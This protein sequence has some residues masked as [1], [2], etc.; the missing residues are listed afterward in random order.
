MLR[1]FLHYY[2][3]YRRLF[4]LDITTAILGA[5][6]ALF[7]PVV[8][9]RLLKQD[10]V[11]KD[12]NGIWIGLG[13]VA[14]LAVLQAVCRFVNTYWGHILGTRMEADMRSDLFRHL[15]KLSYTFYD[16]TKTGHLI[17]RIANDLFNVAELA[18]HG[19]EDLLIS[20]V[21][22]LGSFGFMLWFSPMLALVALIPLPFMVAWAMIFGSKMRRGWRL[23]RQRIADINSGVENAIQ[24]IREVKSFTNEEYEIDRFD[25]ANLEFRRAKE[26]MYGAMAGFHAGMM[27]IMQTYS[28]VIVGGGLVL[29]HSGRIELAD[30]IVFMLYSRFVQQPLHRLTGFVEQFQ[31]GVAAFERFTEIMDVEPDVVDRP[32]A[33]CL[34]SVRGDVTL[35][36]VS[37]RYSENGDWVLNDVTLEIPAGRSVALVGESGAGK[38]TLAALIPRFYEAQRGRVTIDGHDVLDLERRFLRENVGVVQQNVFLFDSTLR[39]NIMFGSPEATE[40]QL[41]EAARRANIL[42]FI[43]SLPEGF[44]STVGEHGVKLSGGQKQRISIARVFLKNPPIL[45]FDE[46]TSSLDSESEQLI[47][48]AM[49]ELCR[50]RT[51]L[52]IAHRFTTVRSADHTYVLSDG[53]IVE[54][55][56]HDEL[57]ERPGYYSKLY[58]Q[59]TI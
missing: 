42:D 34:D 51:T 14:T 56:R 55:G 6:F 16:N 12:L 1:R 47:K 31:Q 18:H 9:G 57:I 46:A 29:A 52:I 33:L 22:I 48:K 10:L 40:E 58:A 2:R 21:M 54:Q 7:I 50:D 37:F 30:I 39:E 25:N 5:A 11:A 3:P 26:Q 28:L 43:E 49:H 19:P 41:I 20:V 8:V 38:S 17:S 4:T 53:K 13:I 45:I 15:Q 23:V 59:S 27:F 35:E 24:G 32:G 44:D 36:N